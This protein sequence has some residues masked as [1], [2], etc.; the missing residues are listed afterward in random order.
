LVFAVLEE[1]LNGSKSK[2]TIASNKK[3]AVL[4]Y[5]VINAIN[6]SQLLIAYEFHKNDSEDQGYYGESVKY[7]KFSA[8]IKNIDPTK[9]DY[10]TYCKSIIADIT[11]TTGTAT[12]EVSIYDN[13]ETYELAEIKYA[14]QHGV[15]NKSEMDSVAKHTI[16][17]YC[18]EIYGENQEYGEND[19]LLYYPEAGNRYTT[20]E[21][22]DPNNDTLQSKFQR[23]V[24]M[25]LFNQQ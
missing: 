13:S 3:E 21:K 5:R 16:A 10:K 2:I 25:K 19:I 22:Y 18:G 17:N 15:L 7:A 4:P 6:D 24:R 1:T 12:L 23:R 8:I 14:K 11:K 20:Q 9:D